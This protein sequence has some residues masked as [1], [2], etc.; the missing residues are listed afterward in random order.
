MKIR[1]QI[2]GIFINLALSTSAPSQEVI[3]KASN[4]KSPLVAT[5][6]QEPSLPRIP[7]VPEPPNKSSPVPA[8]VQ[9]PLPES[10]TASNKYPIDLATAFRLAN[11]QN[12]TIAIAW[13]QVREASARQDQADVLWLPSLVVGGTYIRHDG[14]TQNQRGEV[15]GVSRSSVF[16]GGGT[17]L[18]VDAAE[19]IFQPLVA[20]RLTQAQTAAAR[21]TVNVTQL[22]VAIAY[23]DLLQ[24]HGLLAVNADTLARAEKMLEL[25][26]AAEKSGVSKTA[27]D[28]N[29]A[30]T[31]VAMRRQERIELDGRAAIASGRL[32]R[33]L[34]LDQAVE[35]APADPV[36]VP[37]AL[38]PAD[39][40]LDDL[41]GLALLNRPDLA[42]NRA[43]ALAAWERTRQARYGPFIPKLQVDY[44]AGTFGGGQ[45]S[46][47]GNF[48]A[49]GDL[50]AQAYWELRN[51]GFGNVAQFRER[52]AQQD[53][54]ALRVVEVQAQIGAEVNEAQKTALARLRSLGEAQ[55]AVREATEL[56]RKLLATQFGMVGPNA[57]YDPLEPL[58]AI[59]ALNQ[60]RVQYLNQVIDYNR[61]Q[62]RLFTA[63]GSPAEC[64]LPEAMRQ[65][66]REPVIP[67]KLDDKEIRPKK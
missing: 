43:A 34:L 36:I 19:A 30:R 24:T 65:P 12:P 66:V 27:G 26:R 10:A 15:F 38:L 67:A 59:Q 8:P 47:I 5:A 62:F 22:D 63:I 14:Q 50:T 16:G 55:E 11:A 48:S 2:A 9:L 17:Q 53:Q 42:A 25:A 61:A 31:E 39:L 1:T 46:H 54:A 37:V 3:W 51:F 6:H 58:L 13:A 4:P 40:N 23:L 60:A 32:A 56:Y 41:I 18:R 29:R 28:I 49:R 20:R 44:L 64:A 45:N 52:R 33:L 35:L 7:Q 57:R 21:A